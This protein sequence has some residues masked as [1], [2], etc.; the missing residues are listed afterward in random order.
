LPSIYVGK[1]LNTIRL[2]P[3]SNATF[4]NK[5]FNWLDD[6]NFRHTN[7]QYPVANLIEPNHKNIYP[8]VFIYIYIFL[9]QIGF[10]PDINNRFEFE[11]NEH[12]RI[13]NIYIKITLNW[14]K[15]G[16]Y[17]SYT[18]SG[19]KIISCFPRKRNIVIVTSS[20][21]T[22]FEANFHAASLGENEAKCNVL[23]ETEITASLNCQ[24]KGL[25]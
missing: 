25:W 14:F 1:Y 16:E 11:E 19:S 8:Y 23:S 5:H 13:E 20:T 3:N 9:S 2:S 18:L 17:S 4:C 6:Q 7:Q 10:R 24:K 22:L 21:L 12:I 15:W